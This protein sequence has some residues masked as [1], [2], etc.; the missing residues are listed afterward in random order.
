[1]KELPESAICDLNLKVRHET[2]DDARLA[3]MPDGL[4][5]AE[6]NQRRY[7]SDLRENAAWTKK[8]KPFKFDRR[9]R[10]KK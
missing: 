6:L 9:R 4:M 7:L 1:M 8:Q 5:V 10:R 2:L 3:Q